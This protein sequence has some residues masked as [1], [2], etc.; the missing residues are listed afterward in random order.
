MPEYRKDL[1]RSHNNLGILL[2]NLGKRPEAEEQYRKA[3]AIQ[4]KLAAEFPAVPDYRKDLAPSHN[5]LGILL[6]GLG[7]RPEA[8]EQYR[9]ALAIQEK[10]VAEFPAVPQYRVDLGGGCCNFGIL[11]RDSGQ[12]GESLEWFEKAIRTLT[13][14]YEQD[15]R[16]VAARE[17]LRNSHRDRAMAYDR[18]RKF[19]EAIKDWD[20][21]IELSPDAG[22]TSACA[23]RATSRLQAG[24]VAEAVAEVA[25]LTKNPI[26]GRWSVVQL[27]LRL[28]HCQRQDRRQEAGVCRPGDGTAAKCCE[29]RLERRRTHGQGHGSRCYPWT[30]RLQEADRAVGCEA[31][32]KTQS[33]V[34]CSLQRTGRRPCQ[35]TSRICRSRCA[36]VTYICVF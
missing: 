3:L 5:N 8:E 28:R 4:E 31:S 11:V 36:G 15:R 24:Q 13:A 9:K 25:E 16:L 29:G 12:P 17:F 6:A 33:V 19:T 26:R 20:K 14:V 34:S 35:T 22:A 2:N 23:A 27:C 7:K 30:G 21:A 1:A 10:L 32:L 18:L